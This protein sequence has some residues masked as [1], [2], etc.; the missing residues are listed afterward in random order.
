MDDRPARFEANFSRPE[1]NHAALL[2][3]VEQYGR[4]RG[5][6]QGLRYRL[7]VIVDELVMNAI[8]H[9][10]CTG[11]QNT[12]S[13]GIIDHPNELLIEIIDSGLPFDPTALVSRFPK[14][15]LQISIGGVGLCLV[16]R[17]ADW[18][19][20]TRTKNRN[21]LRL[22]LNKTTTENVCSLKK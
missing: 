2:V 18:M 3:A 9:G 13:V 6:N 16:R 15:T 8:M 4:E 14:D 12:L 5:L 17:L 1:D 19:Q 7:G 21:H 10:G 11:E 22:S 20:Y